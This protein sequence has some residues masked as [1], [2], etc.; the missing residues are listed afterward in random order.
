V[1]I[2]S[3]GLSSLPILRVRFA[4]RTSE[5]KVHRQR[6]DELE[7]GKKLLLSHLA[8]AKETVSRLKTGLAQEKKRSDD[9]EA[10]FTKEMEARVRTEEKLERER[11]LA[12]T[13]YSQST[14]QPAAPPPGSVSTV[15]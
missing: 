15:L 6:A 10:R 3:T 4:R 12:I 8:E 7:S 14:A 1:P 5:S 11:R 13:T 2:D 9:L